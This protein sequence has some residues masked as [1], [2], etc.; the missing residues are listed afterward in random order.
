MWTRVNSKK[1]LAGVTITVGLMVTF[2][3]DKPVVHAETHSEIQDQRSDVQSKLADKK[4]ELESIQAELIEMNDEIS[5]VDEAIKANEKKIK[6]TKDKIEEKQKEVD[7][8]EKEVAAL[9]EDI[10]KRFEILK[11]RAS[12]LQKNGGS[13]QYLDVLFGSKSFGDLIDRVS[14][15]TKI[16]Q[17]DNSLIDQFKA[18]KQKVEEQKAEIETKLQDLKD[19]QA[20][21]EAIQEQVEMQ[22]EQ[23]ESKKAELEEKEANSKDM[24]NDLEL[25]DSELAQME[26]NAKE[27][28]A[29][30]HEQQIE[31]Y[32]KEVEKSVKKSSGSAPVSGNASSIISAGYK[33]IGNSSYQF[34]GGRSS[35]DI[36]RGL[37][38]CSG[39]VSWAFAQGGVN[40]P[41]S[42]SSL[43]GVGQ[44][45]SPS[46]MKPGDL[47]F[48]DTYKTNGHVGIYVGG[49]Q[50]IGSQSS[51]GVAIAN[52][53]SGY[54]A[55]HFSGHVRRVIN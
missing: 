9:E 52:M 33:Y 12:S 34:G 45:V 7:K 8:L 40:L 13:V 11:E 49:N 47:V 28:V 50:F 24:I 14:I 41:A 5:R 32:S 20:E 22:K 25:K 51:T 10:E 55:N 54:W 48:F 23:N 53:G 27:Q 43:S 21:L 6:E 44:K 16:T 36:A 26:A 46:E 39:Y 19:M 30:S 18:D 31:T 29:K 2:P 35:S 42:T 15:V 37:F 4:Q 1:V 3:F 17:A 38:D